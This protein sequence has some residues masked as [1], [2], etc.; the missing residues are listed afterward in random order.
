MKNYYTQQ[1]TL[2][3]SYH[4][5][6]IKTQKPCNSNN[7]IRIF[8]RLRVPLN[9]KTSLLI[10]IKTEI[11]P[12]KFTGSKDDATKAEI[13]IKKFKWSIK[14]SKVADEDAVELIKLLLEGDAA[15]WKF[16]VED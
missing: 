16:D 4:T 6:I 2:F 9:S 1:A 15:K 8:L 5:I 7:L 3:G 10:M 14:F 11:F 13:W 12:Q